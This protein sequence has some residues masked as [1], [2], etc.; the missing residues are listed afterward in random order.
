[1]RRPR[2]PRVHLHPPLVILSL[3]DRSIAAGLFL[4]CLVAYAWFFAG[5]GW[6]QNAHFDLT[7]ALV[8]RRTRHIDGYHTNTGDIAW[9]PMGGIW[10][11][12]INKAPGVSF[13]AAIPYAA[14]YAVE[15][16]LGVPLDSWEVMTLNAWMVT[17]L[18]S[19]LCGALIPVVLYR[20]GRGRGV[21]R[22]RAVLVALAIAF[23]TI[24]FPFSTTLFAQVPSAL[25]LL[26]AFVNL[27]ERPLLAGVFA[28]IAGTCYYVCIPAAVV[29]AFF[30]VRPQP[31]FAI[32]YVAGGAPFALLL[33][34]YHQACFGSPFRSAV[35]LSTSFTQEGLLLGV[36]RAPSAAA[37]WGLTFSEYRGLFF[38][39]PIL[40]LAFAGAVVMWRE[41]RRDLAIVASVMV[42][43][44]LVVASFN[45]WPG[46]FA[47][48]PRYLLPV[49]PLFGMP[50]FF[51]RG[52]ALGTLAVV[53]GALSFGMQFIATSVD[54]TPDAR[55][56]RP[57]REYLWPAFRAGRTS[58]NQQ[59][60]DELVPHS[61][62]PAGSHESSWASA[63]LG[64]VIRGR[65]GRRSS[66]IP[67][68]IWIV[69]GALWVLWTQRFRKAAPSS[70]GD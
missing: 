6:N 27:D 14:I 3:T 7:R 5:G 58:I 25:F 2:R 53:L 45:Q 12:Y 18:T 21:S 34:L 13:L 35:E 11:P 28:G 44:L 17:A 26:L 66:V 65:A 40:L 55:I 22:E 64:E 19:G 47:F 15:R 8:E 57:M 42:V 36:F 37:L 16:A 4:L 9:S 46:G 62:Y 1:M 56:G 59:A 70:S 29:M 54:P 39:S 24:V 23:G 48:G 60:V 51:V 63:N 32:R 68:A 10:R 38:V 31:R 52:R 61:R 69:G 33:A 43:V 67:V 30:I 20:W 41:R 49:I 50:L